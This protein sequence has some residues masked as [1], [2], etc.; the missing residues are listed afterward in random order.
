[1]RPMVAE[2]ISNTNDA[3]MLCR[4]EGWPKSCSSMRRRGGSHW[5]LHRELEEGAADVGGTA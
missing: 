3:M 4:D 2:A 1:M 5:R